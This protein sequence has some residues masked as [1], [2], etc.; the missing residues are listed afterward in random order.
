MIKDGQAVR[1]GWETRRMPNGEIV[2]KK[3]FGG[4]A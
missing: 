1:D 3:S 4:S 2:T